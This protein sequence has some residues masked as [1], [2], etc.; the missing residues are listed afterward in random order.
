MARH[1]DILITGAGGQVGRALRPWLPQ[2]RFLER[3]HLDVT[4]PDAV[5]DA[6]RGTD[7]IIHLA[8]NT[9]VDR[10]EVEAESAHAINHQGTLHVA[11]A[12]RECGSRVIY[13]S[14]DYVFSG[15]ASGEY[16]EDDPT[17]PVNEYGRSKLLGESTLDPDTDLIVRTSWIFGGGNDFIC[18]VLAGSPRE[19][20]V[21]DDQIGRPTRDRDLAEA[22]V[23]ALHVGMTGLIHV[24]GEGA[25]CSWAELAEHAIACAGSSNSVTRIDTKTLFTMCETR[26]A[27]RPANSVLALGKARRLRVPLAP[28]TTAVADYV[29]SLG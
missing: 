16:S 21:V 17:A 23:Y 27:P 6:V 24:A 11:R 1:P 14:T 7:A 13:V 19:I 10:C 29:A 25:P 20:K 28:W 15:K 5:R 12:A 22:L 4:D 3:R 18:N 2:A 9:G 26:V 8:A